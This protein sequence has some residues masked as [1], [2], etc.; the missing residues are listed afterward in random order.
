MVCQSY[1]PRGRLCGLDL[2]FQGGEESVVLLLLA[3][4]H[5][6]FVAVELAHRDGQ[7]ACFPGQRRQY[8]WIRHGLP[9]GVRLTRKLQSRP[10]ASHPGTGAVVGDH[11]DERVVAFSCRPDE[12][13]LGGAVSRPSWWSALVASI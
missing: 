10:A 11:G 12:I 7:F 8:S 9:S 1:H 5:L 2:G 4:F 6:Q 13:T 3:L